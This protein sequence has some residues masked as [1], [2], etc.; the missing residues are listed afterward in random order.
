MPYTLQPVAYRERDQVMRIYYFLKIFILI[1]LFFINTSKAQEIRNNITYDAL[2]LIVGEDICKS[3]AA[4]RSADAST[5]GKAFASALHATRPNSR[6]REK[7]IKELEELTEDFI[8]SYEKNLESANKEKSG[9]RKFDSAYNMAHKASII[10]FKQ[11]VIQNFDKSPRVFNRL[12]REE[13][14]A[15]IA[16]IAEGSPNLSKRSTQEIVIPAHENKR[17]DPPQPVQNPPA[18]TNIIIENPT[19]MGGCIQ[20]GGS[21]YCPPKPTRV[22]PY[23]K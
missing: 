1:S 14:M 16:K 20:D 12:L 7:V 19:V 13:C 23:R 8:E 11:V 6:E 22:S 5:L 18:Q 3:T 21:L 9:D 2:L 15:T 10:I 17:F 4:A